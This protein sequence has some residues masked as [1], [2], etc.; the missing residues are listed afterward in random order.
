ML[1]CLAIV[2]NTTMN[3]G[4]HVSFQIYVFVW[5]W[6][7]Y[8]AVKLLD[9]MIVLFL[10]LSRT[11][12]LFSIVVLPIYIFTVYRVSPFPHPCQYLLFVDFLMI[13]SLTGVR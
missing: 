10:V 8:T 2:N 4:V 5:G 7:V 9:H 12:I 1:P 13:A 3:I 11:F 6:G